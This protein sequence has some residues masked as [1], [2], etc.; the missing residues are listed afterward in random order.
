MTRE[1]VK[2]KPGH[3]YDR[4]FPPAQVGTILKKRNAKVSDTL[5][6]IPVIIRETAW[7][8]KKFAQEVIKA[9]TL[10]KTGSNLWHFVYDHIAYKKDETGKEQVRDAAR[11]WHDRHNFDPQTGEPM[12]CDCDCMTTLICSV[13]YNLG[14]RN[15]YFRV[16]RYE[17]EHWE[18]IY[19]VIKQPNGKEII[20]DCV[21][22]EFNKEAKYTAKQDTPMDL[23]YLNGVSDSTMS[24]LSDAPD[25]MGI[26]DERE[27]LS[28]LGKIFKKKSASGGGRSK[29]AKKGLF[30]KKTAEQKKANKAKVKKFIGKG[31][32]VT[33]R[34]NPVTVALRNGV[35]A[36]MKL[37]FLKVA[38]SLRWSYLTPEQAQAKGADMSKYQK[39]KGVREKLE[40]IFHGAGG[41][42]ENLKKAILTGRGNKDKAVPLNGLG[43]IP[44]ENV[45]GLHEDMPLNQLLGREIYYSENVEGLE[46]LDGF[47]GLEGFS[48]DS[49]LGAATAAS[50]A[51]AS[52]V[53]TTIAALIKSIG[54]V[55]PGKANAKGGASKKEN[56]KTKKAS[57][58]GSGESPGDES[59]GEGSG[60]RT[61]SE[62]SGG[63]SDSSGGEENEGSGDPAAKSNS[64]DE[65]GASTEEK[66]EEESSDEDGTTNGNAAA[67][68]GDGSAGSNLKPATLAKAKQ[69]WENNK[70]WIKP[71]GIAVGVL[72]LVYLT[73]RLLKANSPKKPALG[74]TGIGNKQKRKPTKKKNI[75]SGIRSKK[76]GK[77]PAR[78]NHQ[79][80]K[81]ITLL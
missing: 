2:V 29:P 80:R 77:R 3:E 58:R 78:R 73:H 45:E 50:V 5:K 10:E 9:D 66:S 40:K 46:G 68:D 54:S 20:M 23:E 31:L 37:N 32:H 25:L 27:A 59:G 53:L 70:K 55:F 6:L 33:N 11:I 4:Y 71:T 42:P 61:E 72:G 21:L 64:G 43:Y 34:I 57:K 30:K 67:K 1:N 81:V 75:L 26:M 62:S 16:T 79:K 38:E 41:K 47:E 36:G 74:L 49:D 7:Q 51:A 69:F 39:L 60:E 15:V 24:K 35:L 12:G 65:S 28:A 18:H 17:E 52:T 76:G 44:Y 48:E 19:P 14:V 63:E 13:L 22:H 56:R 8:T